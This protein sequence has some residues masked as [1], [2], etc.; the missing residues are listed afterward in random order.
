MKISLGWLRE[1]VDL[2]LPLPQLIEKLNMIGLMVDK[3][4]EKDGDVVLDIETYANRPD[5]L[6]HLGIARELAAA[7][8]L[9]LKEKIWPVSEIGE[10]TADLIDVQVWDEQLCPRYCGIIVK[11]IPV[12]PS[13][14]WLQRRIAAMGLKPIN[15][16]VDVS[17]YVLFDT[18]QPIHAFDLAKIG[19][20]KIIVRRAKKGETLKTLEGK[21][22]SLAPEMLVIADEARPMALAGVIGGEDSAV[23]ETTRD[24]FIECAHFDPVS[25]RL[26]SKAAG[27]Q[28][29]ASYRFE[30]GTDFAFPPRAAIMAGSLL[31]RFGGK[32]T[33]EIVDVCP[34]PRKAKSLVLRHQRTC[35]LL[36]TEVEPEFI[37]KTLASLGF[38]TDLQQRGVWRVE[39]PSYRVDIEREADLIEEV[40][41]FYGYD[42][43]PSIVTPLKSFEP[44]VNKRRE[45]TEKVRTLLLHRGFDEAINFSFADP[46][47]EALLESGRSSISLCNPIS[48]KASLL[49]TNLLQGLLE[50][51]AW[52]RNRGVDGIH[53]FE[54]G[55]VYFWDEK[56][57]VEQLGLGL[58]TTGLLDPIHW[59]G[60]KSRADYFTLKG[61]LEALLEHLR[62][63][64]SSFVATGH[65]FFEAGYSLAVA[66]KN[67]K[68]GYL[69]LVRR[70]ILDAYSLEGPVY[71]A[72]INL[73]G[74]FGKQPQPFQY[75]PVVKFPAVVRDL[76]VLISRDIAYQELERMIAKLAVPFL[77]GFEL[78]D[79]FE[80]PAI[81]KDKVSLTLRFTFRHPQRTL[82]AEE[83][84]KFE[85]EMVNHLKSVFD[86]QL[87]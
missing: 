25:V 56:C 86:I 79:L 14:P 3:W 77:E 10:R 44:T 16:I 20:R 69:G 81:P 21:E 5:T 17:N 48:I 15:N 37:A 30:R 75:R 51:T 82:L 27:I 62:Y 70:K 42:K 41:R 8:E 58:V 28:T 50:N 74:L 60:E 45:R 34:K 24:V 80:G 84:D 76:S 43:I 55:N 22:L 47:R 83:V 1:Y 78:Y 53:L 4:E 39:V 54:L 46:E 64:P 32:V 87:R 9:P 73:S 40:A 18:A 61:A 71:A 11:G 72:E 68:I 7:L 2:N 29:D 38:K 31:T 19:G 26:T 59:R 6:G 85:Q 33:Q 52:N 57:H 49:R 35:D 12:S 67:E 66:Y 23:V 13:P 36:G 65:P 63:S